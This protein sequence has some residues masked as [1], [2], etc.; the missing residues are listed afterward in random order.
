MTFKVENNAEYNQYVQNLVAAGMAVESKTGKFTTMGRSGDGNAF[1]KGDIITLPDAIKVIHPVING[2]ASKGEAIVVQITNGDATRFGL[3]Y[4]S[5]LSKRTIVVKV[6]DKG[7]AVSEMPRKPG[8]TAAQWYQSRAGQ[9]NQQI[10]EDMLK[11]GKQIK[12]SMVERVLQ[13]VYRGEGLE[14]TMIYD[15]DFV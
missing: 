12:V 7:N 9:M 5:A 15:F 13:P 10:M 1:L 14:A 6:D 3:F 2:V 4:P 11:E 8:G